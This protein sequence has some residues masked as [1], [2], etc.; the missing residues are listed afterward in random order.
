MFGID[1]PFPRVGK[2]DVES[3]Q[4]PLC[5]QVIELPSIVPSHPSIFDVGRENLLGNQNHPFE[6]NLHT[7]PVQFRMSSSHPRQVKP[8]TGSDLQ[9]QR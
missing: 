3:A 8:I 2:V 5:K 4:L 1:V 6:S 7:K 9:V